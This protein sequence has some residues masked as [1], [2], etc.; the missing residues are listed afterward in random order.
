MKSPRE[1]YQNDP[2]YAAL[3]NSLWSM[4]EAAEMTPSEVREAAI[5]AC[6]LYEERKPRIRLA[7]RS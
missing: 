1:K 7:R 2:M 3:V 5:L 4:I 6:T